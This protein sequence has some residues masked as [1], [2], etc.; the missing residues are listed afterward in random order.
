MSNK[1]ILNQWKYRLREFYQ[2]DL[3]SL[4]ASQRA[5]LRETEFRER[6]ARDSRLRDIFSE[7]EDR[8]EKAKQ[9]IELRTHENYAEFKL[10]GIGAQKGGGIRG[11][12]RGFSRKSRKGMI[13]RMCSL[14]WTPRIFQGLTIPDDVWEREGFTTLTEK[15]KFAALMMKKTKEAVEKA[16]PGTW[17]IWKKEWEPRKYGKFK[18]EQMPHYHWM[19]DNPRLTKENC[20]TYCI[21]VVQIWLRIIGTNHPDAYRVHINHKPGKE[22]PFAYMESTKMAQVYMC[23]Y[24][25]KVQNLD[26]SETLGRFHGKIGN[27][28]VGE[29]MVH[30]LRP[31]Y[32]KWLKRMLPKLVHTKDRK[33][34]ER[35]K[36]LLHNGI[37]FVLVSRRTIEQLF[38]W[39]RQMELENLGVTDCPF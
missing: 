19:W 38:N 14:K 5:G 37:G 20:V 9:V 6:V 11:K 36:E 4:T 25:A 8:K 24:V 35:V 3:E 1:G 29:I 21:Q 15:G 10:P 16:I 30:T 26:T 33:V 39:I 28:E 13:K 2:A 32:Y 31:L 18:G 23:K 7:R 22:P 12:I 34:T 27:P 17:G